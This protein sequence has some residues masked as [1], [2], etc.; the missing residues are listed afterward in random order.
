MRC[1]LT[2]CFCGLG[3]R[4]LGRAHPVLTT[5]IDE[6][7]WVGSVL[8]TPRDAVVQAPRFGRDGWSRAPGFIGHSGERTVCGPLWLGDC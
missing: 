5:V 3:F 8:L 6:L 4:G 7:L 2:P 1:G